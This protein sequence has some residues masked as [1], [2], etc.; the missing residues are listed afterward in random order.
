MKKHL[1][2]NI[3]LRP[4]FDL[5]DT[6]NENEKRHHASTLQIATRDLAHIIDVK[7]LIETLSPE[8]INK[9]GD[10]ILFNEKLM[11]LGYSFQQD[12]T[13]LSMSFPNF[14]HKFSEF[15]ED[16]INIDECVSEVSI[17]QFKKIKF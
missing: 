8:M 6:S 16:V 17:I 14:V 9:F 10:L 3:F 15:A 1:K 12:A 7:F 4:S 13:K 11:K 5:I 2:F